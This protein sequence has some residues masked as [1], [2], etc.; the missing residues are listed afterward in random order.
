MMG[1]ASSFVDGFHYRKAENVLYCKEYVTRFDAVQSGI[2][3][4]HRYEN[5]YPK[6]I[7]L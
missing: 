1:E 4:V 7:V 2:R 5:I 6:T 3:H